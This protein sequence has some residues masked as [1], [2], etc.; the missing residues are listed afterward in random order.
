LG[1]VTTKVRLFREVIVGTGQLA[2]GGTEPLT[3]MGADLHAEFIHG[4]LDAPLGPTLLESSPCRVTQGLRCHGRPRRRF[5]LCLSIHFVERLEAHSDP[6]RVHA[7]AAARNTGSFELV[8]QVADRL[9]ARLAGRVKHDSVD[10]AALL[11]VLDRL[12]GEVQ[13]EDLADRL[14]PEL[15]GDPYLVHGSRLSGWAF[16][17]SWSSIAIL[18]AL[19]TERRSRSACC[20]S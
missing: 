3:V 8:E 2:V 19:D 15:E 11:G 1:N 12:V 10:Q 7:F 14:V 17:R 13:R 9:Q 18:I 20:F 5:H 4:D 6:D 16:R